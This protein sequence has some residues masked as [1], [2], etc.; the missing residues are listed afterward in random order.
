MLVT[1]KEMLLKAQKGN[2]AVGAFN[3]ENME[4]VMAV[5][6]AA[7]ELNAPVIMQTTPSTV[8]YAGLDYYLANV[9]T[10]AKNAKVPV[11]MHLDHGSSFSLAM[12]A[13]RQG[14]TSI[15]I[16]G[17]HSVFEENIAI[18][19]SVVDACKPSNIPV[20]AELGKVGG[21]E[22]DLD[23]GDGGYTDPK[24]AL[25]FVQKTGVNSLAVAIGTAHGV[26]KGEPKLDLDRL[27]EISKVVDVPLVLHGASGLSEEAVKESIKR[28][29]CKVNFATELRIAYT[30]GVKEL[31]EEKP[32][33]IDPKKYGVVGIEKVK[34][35]VKNRMM[36]CGCQNQA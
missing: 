4:M 14:Y 16:D 1:T 13:L 9:A 15:M 11:A 27:V 26:Y 17:S 31:L 22:D 30:D 12:Q 32:E 19:K 8:K 25:E 2:Y 24:E 20:E 33:T 7:E 36:M 10:A 18:T 3:V 21:K 23:G 34:E 28:G 5:I 29:I 6:A 35:L